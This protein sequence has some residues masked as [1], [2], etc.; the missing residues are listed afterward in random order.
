MAADLPEG[1]RLATW[2]NVSKGGFSG[3]NRFKAAGM[4]PTGE[5]RP[6][7]FKDP[8]IAEATAQKYGTTLNPDGT[9]NWPILEKPVETTRLYRITGASGNFTPSVDGTAE[10]AGQ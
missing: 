9:I 2:G 7:A 4:K 5:V 8:S 3:L 10:F 1:A 6:L